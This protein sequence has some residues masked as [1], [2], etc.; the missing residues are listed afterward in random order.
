MDFDYNE[1]KNQLLVESRGIGFERVIDE[2]ESNNLVANIRH[3]KSS[4]YKNQFL[5]LVRIDDYI[6]VVPYVKDEKRNVFF[7][8]TVYPSR[9]FTKIYLKK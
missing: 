1:E 7:L 3:F 2:I 5:F 8:K 4:R 9:K 6:Y